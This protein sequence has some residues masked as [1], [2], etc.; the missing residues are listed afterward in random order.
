[1]ATL[2]QL[3]D[4][5]ETISAHSASALAIVSAKVFKFCMVGDA[6][7]FQITYA[8]WAWYRGKKGMVTTR[9]HNP[10]SSPIL[11][12]ILSRFASLGFRSSIR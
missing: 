8:Q 12:H 1:V 5:M 7:S 9:N 4:S 10:R 6:K 3:A 11:P 2:P